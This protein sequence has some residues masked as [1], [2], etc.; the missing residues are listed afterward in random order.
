MPKKTTILPAHHWP[1]PE[2]RGKTKLRQPFA[3][4]VGLALIALLVGAAS[5]AQAA[6]AGADREATAS[7]FG[8][9]GP[10]ERAV[11]QSGKSCAQCH[12]GTLYPAVGVFEA[13]SKT[14]HRVLFILT[15][16]ALLIFA[17]GVLSK[18]WLWTRGS[19][20]SFHK[21]IRWSKVWQA[22]TIS[23]IFQPKIL[24]MNFWRWFIFFTI[25]MGFVALF[26]VSV[27]A[28]WSRDLFHA[29]FFVEG[30]GANLLECSM[31]F[32]GLA[33]LVGIVAALVR[34]Y[35]VKP[36]GLVNRTEDLMILVML[37]LILVT[38][39]LL[40]ACRLAAYPWNPE[41]RFAFVGNA[42]AELIRRQPDQW[43]TAHYYLWMIHAALV[44]IFIAAIPFTKI[45]HFMAAPLV[46][47]AT[48][49]EQPMHEFQPRPQGPTAVP[50]GRIKE[51]VPGG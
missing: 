32:L 15:T 26:L 21:K 50:V 11:Q 16:I 25:S 24:R 46:I 12:N 38:G 40:E 23:V 19:G 34:R 18:V 28:G 14:K 35:L 27:V 1:G 17:A 10:A 22:L 4:L 31:D 13:Q 43:L 6:P 5:S 47:L 30:V 33:M 3:V 29:S 20:K 39:F 48:A 7:A 36:E 41:M 2:W 51:E 9:H 44:C 49:S 42:L 37:L 45:I 8:L